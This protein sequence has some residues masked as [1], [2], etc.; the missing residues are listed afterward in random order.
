MSEPLK[1]RWLEAV[2]RMT[3]AI[4]HCDEEDKDIT[5]D[6]LCEAA[7]NADEIDVA[8]SRALFKT[9]IRETMASELAKALDAAAR[10]L[11]EHCEGIAPRI[12]AFEEILARFQELNH[13]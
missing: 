2:V 5:I 3:L 11:W 13:E 1:D 6:D 7:S 10:L 8:K 9:A 4:A 12:E